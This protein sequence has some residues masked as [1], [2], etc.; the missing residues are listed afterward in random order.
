MW[1]K[2]VDDAYYHHFVKMLDAKYLCGRIKQ[3]KYCFNSEPANGLCP[4][5][6]RRLKQADMPAKPRDP[7]KGKPR[8]LT[9]ATI[10]LLLRLESLIGGCWNDYT[11]NR[12]AGGVLESEGR[13]FVY[14]LTFLREN[15]EKIQ[16]R[17]SEKDQ[18]PDS[19]LTHKEVFGGYYE[20]GSN[21]YP[22]FENLYQIILYIEVRTPFCYEPVEMTAKEVEQDTQRKKLAEGTVRYLPVRNMS[23][24][25]KRLMVTLAYVMCQ[26]RS[27]FALRAYNGIV[28]QRSIGNKTT[29]FPQPS[30][31]P[32]RFGET[33]HKFSVAGFR[34]M[35]EDTLL[36]GCCHYGAN[37][38]HVFHNANK[39]LRYLEVRYELEFD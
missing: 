4:D 33:S 37:E 20:F 29:R 34:A 6:L 7:N 36:R 27:G 18:L 12:G 11:Q 9:Q 17:R 14:P 26:Y 19:G 31:Y 22:V 25:R 10:D 30:I 2:N 5:C 21:Q 23:E 39:V 24:D 38:F 28:S 16:Y 3:A 32:V 13:G 1:G 8:E 15:G 35:P